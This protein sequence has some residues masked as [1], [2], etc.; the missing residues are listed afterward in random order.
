MGINWISARGLTTN[1]TADLE[2]RYHKGKIN[3][4]SFAFTQGALATKLK[5]KERVM[6]GVNN[7]ATRLYFAPVDEKQGYKVV[8]NARK[9]IV[10]VSGKKMAATCPTLSPSSVIGTYDLKYDEVEKLYYISIG[11]LP[12]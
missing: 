11:A 3:R 7:S 1:Q 9:A 8:K 12:R 6:V 4:Y 5:N 10:F 2:V